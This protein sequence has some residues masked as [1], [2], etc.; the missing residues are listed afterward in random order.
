MMEFEYT[1]I[2]TLEKHLAIA[3]EAGLRFAYFGNVPGHPVENTYCPE[4][5]NVVVKRYGF[6]ML[7]WNLD[8]N[9]CC[10]R[11]KCAI[12]I[13]GR[14]LEHADNR[15]NKRKRYFQLMGF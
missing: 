8:G 1:P 13:K 11:C 2:D 9:N 7:S 4:C 10:N 6:D 15:Q 14:P 12:P 3:K 5:S